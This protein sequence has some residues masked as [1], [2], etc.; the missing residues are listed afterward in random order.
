MI[1]ILRANAKP[2]NSSVWHLMKLASERKSDRDS[3]QSR[4]VQCR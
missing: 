1:G 3:C 4:V 2:I